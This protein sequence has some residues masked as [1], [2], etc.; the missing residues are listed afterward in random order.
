MKTGRPNLMRQ[1]RAFE[2]DQISGGCPMGIGCD[3][4]SA[5]VQLGAG[6]IIF[7]N[8]NGNIYVWH[9]PVYV[10]VYI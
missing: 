6:I 5:T 1:L 4:P 10:P 8:C 2:L 3:C 7:T 9:A